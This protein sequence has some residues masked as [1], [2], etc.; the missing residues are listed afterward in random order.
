MRLYDRLLDFFGVLTGV[1]AAFLAI[2]I[3]V[4]VIGR[5]FDVGDIDWIIEAS[6]YSLFV[7]TFLGAPWAL[8]E[9]VHIRVD[10]A[11]NLLSAR[12]QKRVEFLADLLGLFAV[13]VLLIWGA[14]VA[15]ASHEAHS[16]YSKLL[17]FP[18]WTLLILIPISAALMVVELCRR[19]W[20]TAAGRSVKSGKAE[21]Y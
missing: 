17:I 18:E 1:I 6:E 19:L 2:G 21:V 8:R 3:T 11:T 10:I 15:I 5:L 4:S 7:M 9:G 14:K 16:M 20:R 12:W 13:G